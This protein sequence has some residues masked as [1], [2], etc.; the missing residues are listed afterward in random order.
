MHRRLIAQ[1]FLR[2]HVRRT[3]SLLP[4]PA[5]CR[6]GIARENPANGGTDP[7]AQDLARSPVRSA[8]RAGRSIIEWTN[9]VTSSAISS[10]WSAWAEMSN[11]A[12][13]RSISPRVSSNAALLVT[14][15]VAAPAPNRGQLT[16]LGV[17][18]EPLEEQAANLRHHFGRGGTEVDLHRSDT[19]TKR[20]IDR[21]AT[22][23]R[24][25]WPLE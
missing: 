14:S 21:S 4:V 10:R 23:R 22:A 24:T 18:R 11:E 17:P 9:P 12:P 19:S 1:G 7:S 13:A 20:F 15:S 6:F 16:E 3:A 2:Y 5:S 25:A 8:G